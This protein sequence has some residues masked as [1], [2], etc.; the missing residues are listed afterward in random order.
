MDKNTDTKKVK[1][2]PSS[3]SYPKYIQLLHSI[4][5][6]TTI[7]LNELLHL[8]YIDQEDYNQKMTSIEDLWFRIK[9]C[10][11][12][13][14]ET[15]VKKKGTKTNIDTIFTDLFTSVKG[16]LQTI[17]T[18]EIIDM[19]KIMK[20]NEINDEIQLNPE[21]NQYMDLC[22]QYFMI[23]SIQTYEDEN[24]KKKFL[25]IQ[26]ISGDENECV[27][28]KNLLVTPFSRNRQFAEKIEGASIVFLYSNIVYVFHGI[29][30]K[31]SLG[32]CKNL[33]LFIKKMKTFEED[34][35]YI[36]VPKDFKTKYAEQISLR[37]FLIM[38]TREIATMIKNDYQEFTNL[39]GKTLSSIIKDFIKSPP[40]KQRKVLI[41]FL[42]GDEES[43]FNAHIIYDLI[44]TQNIT[45]QS[46][47]LAEMIYRSFHWKIQKIFKI[48]QKSYED[49]KKKIENL[50]IQD[51]PYETRIANLKV[52]DYVKSKAMD[53]VKEIQGSKEN[54][55]KAQQWL[56][57]FLK[58]PF[59]TYRNEP[60]IHQSKGFFDNIDSY[61][62]QLSVDILENENQWNGEEEREYMERMK[63]IVEE[64][65]IRVNR[66][67]EN[68]Y[69]IFLRNV[70]KKLDE[71][72]KENQME[73]DM[74]D[75]MEL[76][77]NE[78]TYKE[79]K[80]ELSV[81]QTEWNQKS[82]EM[83]KEEWL[84]K[85]GK[86]EQKIHSI[87]HSKSGNETPFMNFVFRQ[88]KRFYEFLVEWNELK[89]KKRD[90][91][92]NVENIL[93]KC[94]YGQFEA[95]KQMKRLIAQWINGNHEKGSVIGLQGPPGVGKTSLL[96]H[97]LSKCL[98]DEN[99]ESRPL[100]FVP[101]G[102]SSNGSFLE[103]HNYTYLGSTW[104]K[105]VDALMEAKCMNPIIFI[106]ELDKVSKTEHGK[107]IASILTHITDETQNTEFFDRYFA[108]I[109]IDLSRVLFVFS[110]N[111]RDL[112]DPI[113][114]DRIQEI[115]IQSLSNR[116]KVVIS[117]NYILP[118]IMENVGFTMDEIYF[119]HEV[120][121]YL[122]ES[123]TNESGCRR[124]KEILLNIVR[125]INVMKI[126]GE[127]T[128]FPFHVT[129]EFIDVFM[130]DKPKVTHDKI[131]KKP[132]I[133]VS[134]GLYAYSSGLCGGI[135]RIQ[136]IYTYNGDGK[137]K[138]EKMTGMM[139]DSMKE[140]VD[141]AF[142]LA[143]NLLPEVK[144]E[145]LKNINKGLHVLA[146][147]ISQKDGPSATGI[148]AVSIFSRLMNIAVKNDIASTGEADFLGNLTK[149]GGLHSKLEGAMK[150]GIRAVVIC[151]EN[152]EDLDSLIRKEKDERRLLQRSSSMKC[153]DLT[154]VIG[155]M[156]SES[157]SYMEIDEESYLK[158]KYTCKRYKMLD[159]YVV[160]TI[161]DLLDIV[162]VEKVELNRYM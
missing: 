72:K 10:E 99:G 81:L 7:H 98:V 53:K 134:N 78:Q 91:L 141:V 120:L 29:F 36:D 66:K 107:E 6:K 68:S 102:G 74:F 97:G 94:T 140:S 47:L 17:G 129:K 23:F 150:C 110:Y 101:I 64:Y 105:I 160:D 138:I 147:S 70:E 5:H 132:L 57:G 151:R 114:K 156:G 87:A 65:R 61:M 80:Y 159:V 83:K 125:E 13:S 30:Q 26:N 33:P 117:K 82:D 158:N 123:Y 11:D 1:I 37:D 113:L 93:D 104:G 145:E 161:Y 27:Y 89:H 3:K 90:Y 126:Q 58:I 85:I 146:G 130:T 20:W 139:G 86:I 135:T 128:E 118:E 144:K 109:P 54:S 60:I 9:E 63:Y 25:E 31:D 92:Q 40:E 62:Q 154:P 148:I 48:T 77:Q 143:Y 56:D 38:S 149:I 106:D 116:E 41:L 73:E 155:R 142:S 45:Y 55:N 96:K 95:K 22:N 79:C 32:L 112:V 119:S 137:L 152:E 43:K 8:R 12:K 2:K 51:I 46:V 133:G 122:I 15:N 157:F 21:S 18:K 69:E 131:H 115:Q 103:G 35:E 59:G 136:T 108:S 4:I 127:I 49:N 24:E 52:S 76:E 71:I 75:F 50:S 42:L 111:D 88:M 121:E 19:I 67:S 100:I 44:S 34:I 14:N 16:L 124:C 39:K 28:L 84:E 162:L 153:M